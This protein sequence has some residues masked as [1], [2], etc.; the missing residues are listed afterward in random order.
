MKDDAAS[1]REIRMRPTRHHVKNR[2]KRAMVILMLK[3]V[4]S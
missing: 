3:R 2:I 1:D 4:P